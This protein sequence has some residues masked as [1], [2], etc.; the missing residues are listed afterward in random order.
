VQVGA[1]HVPPVHTELL[2]SEAPAQVPPGAHGGQDPPPQSTSV[3]PPF[4]TSSLQP[5]DAQ[6]NVA[7]Q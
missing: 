5:G 6:T 2:Q 7:E 3:S 1:L 4:L